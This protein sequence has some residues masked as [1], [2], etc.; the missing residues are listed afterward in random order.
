[1]TARM[2][3]GIGYASLLLSGG[4][5]A[6]SQSS[7][8]AQP[9]T[10]SA[11]SDLV[12]LNVTV[13]DKHGGYAAGLDRDAFRLFDDDQPRPIDFFSVVDTPVTVGLLIDDSAS[14]AGTRSLMAAA[15]EAFAATSNPADEVFA[16]TFNDRVRSVF[17]DDAPFAINPVVLKAAVEA[18]LTS[19]GRTVLHDAVIEGMAYAALGRHSRRVL[20]VISDG[21]DTASAIDFGQLLQSVHASST[22]VYTVAIRDPSGDGGRPDRLKKLA[23]ATG[24]QA[25][26]P[27]TTSGIAAALTAIA[28]DIRHAYTLGYAPQRVLDPSAYHRLRVTARNGDGEALRVRTRQGYLNAEKGGTR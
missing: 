12:V 8:A 24:G 10:F 25:F 18:G 15:A 7:T 20:V 11:Q 1:M 26:Q 9:A 6:P 5:A 19:R 4:A 14:M 17:S 22:V 28:S 3:L 21:D 13:T 23:A 16:L 2:L 27:R